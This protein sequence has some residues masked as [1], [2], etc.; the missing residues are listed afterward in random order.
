[1]TRILVVEDEPT[2]A[3][4]LHDDLTIEGFQVEVASD[5]DAGA[6]AAG[7]GGFDLILLDVMLPGKDGFTVCREL[8]AAGVHVPIILL[9]ARGQES[10]KVLGLG[11]GADDYVTKPFSPRELV[12]RVHAVL[13]RAARTPLG[14]SFGFGD[15]HVDFARHEVRRD[16]RPV[17]V[18][19][20]EFKL[21]RVLI[22]RRGEVV[23]IDDLLRDGWG[24]DVFLTDRVVY[25][26]INNL[27]AKI[28]PD[29]RRPRHIVSVRG[30]G[31]RFEQ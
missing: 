19:P 30:V 29:P 5:G 8:R 13:R 26:H 12:A 14:R 28:E 20:S 21:L 22:E 27:R 31:Y 18:T 24:A 2:I 4:G 11:L 17:D 3:I 7:R 1:M 16:G 10:D 23:S 25:T 9:T 6:R 15:A